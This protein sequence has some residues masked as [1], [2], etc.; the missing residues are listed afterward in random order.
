M[1]ELGDSILYPAQSKCIWRVSFVSILSC[2]Y[3]I[4]NR[5]YDLAVIPGG[6][7]M[8]SLNYWRQPTYGW[9]RNLDMAYV[10]LALVYQNKRAYHMP[11]AVQY[12]HLVGFGS[13]LYPLN[14]Y[15]YKKSTTGGQQLH[16]V[17][18]TLWLI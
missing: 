4:Y 12:Y 3:A 13:L 2:S 8:T 14:V 16:T 18:Y 11:N 17:C 5:H 15:L 7:F 6:V 9:R 1:D 10:A